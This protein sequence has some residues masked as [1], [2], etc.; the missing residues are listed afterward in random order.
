MTHTIKSK[1]VKIRKPH[2]CISCL[3][4]GKP[5]HEMIYDVVNHD[6]EMQARYFCKTCFTLMFQTK[7]K[8]IL[9]D[10]NEFDEGCVDE[11][12]RQEGVDEPEDLL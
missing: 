12:V 7:Y 3:R 5:G 11:L 4:I 2:Q 1:N 9:I 10:A 8:K 6:G